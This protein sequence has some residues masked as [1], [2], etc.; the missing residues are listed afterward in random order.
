MGFGQEICEIHLWGHTAVGNDL[1]GRKLGGSI[2]SNG[3]G[4]RKEQLPCLLRAFLEQCLVRQHWWWQD[5]HLIVK[6]KTSMWKFERWNGYIVNL[7]ELV[8]SEAKYFRVRLETLHPAELRMF[9]Y[10]E[11]KRTTRCNGIYTDESE[12]NT[13]TGVAF[14]IWNGDDINHVNAT[15]HSFPIR[16]SSY[17]VGTIVY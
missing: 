17:K 13:K 10:Q 2:R 4:W 12:N 16:I 6:E 8:G 9:V 15:L 11:M 1:W 7:Q 14:V 5:L 3:T